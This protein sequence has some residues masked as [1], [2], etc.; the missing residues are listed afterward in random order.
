MK[1]WKMVVVV[2]VV[3]GG[4]VT[5]TFMGYSPPKPAGPDREATETNSVYQCDP[6]QYRQEGGRFVRDDPFTQ[7]P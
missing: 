7:L 3:S 4:I 2:V 1:T 6:R 5:T